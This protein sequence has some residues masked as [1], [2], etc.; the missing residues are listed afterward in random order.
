MCFCVSSSSEM[1]LVH[2]SVAWETHGTVPGR[3]YLV[4]RV[5]LEGYTLGR[6]PV[7]MERVPA[8][9]EPGPGGASPS[10]TPWRG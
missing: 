5:R 1:A 3:G 6:V 8:P 9:R 10:E 4:D 2:S 7:R